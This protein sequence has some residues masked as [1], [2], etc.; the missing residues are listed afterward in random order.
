MRIRSSGIIALPELRA[1]N[2]S[3]TYLKQPVVLFFS[4]IDLQ[5]SSAATEQTD[6]RLGRLILYSKN[7][8]SRACLIS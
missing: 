7:Q 6:D 8:I 2:P 4:Q 1:C 5:G 3:N